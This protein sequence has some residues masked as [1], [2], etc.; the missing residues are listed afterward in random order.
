MNADMRVV[1]I[2]S[3][4]AGD[5]IRV[6]IPD[7]RD[8]RDLENSVRAAGII[9]P[10]VV[11]AL[12]A[13]RYRLVAGHRRYAAA[14]AAGLREVPVI[15]QPD[16]E[17]DAVIQL[18]ENTQRAAMDPLDVARALV[19]LLDDAPDM[20]QEAL[21]HRMGRSPSYISDALKKLRR[22]PATQRA[23][24]RGRIKGRAA[25][26]MTNQSDT[27]RRQLVA[28]ADEPGVL[29]RVVTKP[30]VR[31]L[32]VH[33][34]DGWRVV[35]SWDGTETARL[36]FVIAKDRYEAGVRFDTEQARRMARA[37]RLLCDAMDQTLVRVA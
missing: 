29:K 33:A 12:G 13:G 31:T 24:A 22:D 18:I 7:E 1:A 15:V 9:Q 3:I 35:V 37:L 32:T 23:I 26:L 20:T 11:K 19:T 36:D 5:N 16:D 21:A 34:Q 2:E 14:E 10:L 27:E 17:R 8:D 25:S 6:A 4:I 30:S 28:M